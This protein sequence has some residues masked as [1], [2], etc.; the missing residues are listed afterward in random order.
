MVNGAHIPSLA[1]AMTWQYR[2][3]AKT[4]ANQTVIG[5]VLLAVLGKA[6]SHPPR[7]GAGAV[8]TPEG[9]VMALFQDR[10]LKKTL[11]P[12]SPIGEFVDTFRRLADDLKLGDADRIA[13][14]SE[15][16]KWIIKD[17]RTEP[18]PLF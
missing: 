18:S 4:K 2:A 12:I 3:I 16:R 15:V 10:T 8:I 6:T 13:M 11:A 7:F 14:F 1:A 17:D 5:A 9:M